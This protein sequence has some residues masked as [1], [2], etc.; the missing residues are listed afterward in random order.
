MKLTSTSIIMGLLVTAACATPTSVSEIESASAS[1]SASASESVSK[2]E[3][4][5]AASASPGCGAA[6]SCVG[7]GG[8]ELCNDRCKHCSGPSG[9]Y[10][11]GECC[12]FGWHVLGLAAAIIP[13]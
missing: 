9:Q 7:T 2:T 11:R 1:T 8:G 5:E 10:T 13:S 3:L 12:G 6:G 4:V